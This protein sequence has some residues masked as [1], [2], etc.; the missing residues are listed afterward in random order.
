MVVA[1]VGLP[2]P[3]L[4]RARMPN[5]TPA[6][7]LLEE[8]DARQNELLDE[9]DRLNGQIER[10]IAE[11]TTARAADEHTLPARAA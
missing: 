6:V 11:W 5:E 2:T 8:L 3:L 9:L 7:S 10:V 4:L 1:S